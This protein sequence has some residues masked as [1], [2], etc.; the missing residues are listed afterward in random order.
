MDWNGGVERAARHLGS[1]GGELR[2]DDSGD[3][4][5]N[6]EINSVLRAIPARDERESESVSARAKGSGIFWDKS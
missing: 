1:V 4:L 3:P 2:Q 6:G 5:R